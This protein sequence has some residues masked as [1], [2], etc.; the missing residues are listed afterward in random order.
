MTKNANYRKHNDGS[1]NSSTYHKK[2]GTPIRSILKREAIEEIREH[3][4]SITLATLPYA[5]DQEVFD[6]VS[7][8]LLSQGCKSVNYEENEKCITMYCLYRGPNGTKCAA[9]CLI[10]D[11]EYKVEMENSTWS[12]LCQHRIVPF[13]HQ[14]L[15]VDLQKIHDDYNPDEWPEKLKQLANNYRL[16]M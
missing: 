4:M 7:K 6:H 12:T 15:I 10:D 9:G 11:T 16:K 8:H 2:D 13:S 1:H 3:E 5:T 14:E